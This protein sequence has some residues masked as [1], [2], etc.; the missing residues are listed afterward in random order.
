MIPSGFDQVWLNAGD[1][2]LESAAIE[3]VLPDGS[4]DGETTTVSISALAGAVVA[5]DGGVPY[6]LQQTGES[7]TLRYHIE[8]HRKAN[9]QGGGGS[10]YDKGGC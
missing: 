10:L 7:V 1:S 2:S 3:C 6:A 8:I 9:G 4:I 5:A